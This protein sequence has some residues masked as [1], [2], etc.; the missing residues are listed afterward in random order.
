VCLHSDPLR[1]K[2]KKDQL[3]VLKRHQMLRDRGVDLF[4]ELRMKKYF[5]ITEN[6]DSFIENSLA[7]LIR[8]TAESDSKALAFVLLYFEKEWAELQGDYLMALEI[9]EKM[10]AIL[11][12]AFYIPQV[13]SPYELVYEQARILLELDYR[14]QATTILY[15]AKDK[16]DLENECAQAVLELLFVLELSQGHIQKAKELL[17]EFCSSTFFAKY[18]PAHTKTKWAYYTTV[19]YFRNNQPK[20]FMSYVQNNMQHNTLELD[21]KLR[22]KLMEILVAVDTHMFDYADRL[23]E[24]LRKFVARNN[25]RALIKMPH[26]FELIDLLWQ[27]KYCGYDLNRLEERKV[28]LDRFISKLKAVYVQMPLNSSLIRWD[29]WFTKKLMQKADAAQLYYQAIQERKQAYI[30]TGR[31]SKLFA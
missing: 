6:L 29:L 17:E 12:T 27:L 16:L 10:Q 26:L 4:L 23:Q 13:Q 25:L 3:F 24:S 14:D 2:E 11:E 5:G 18:I 1:F 7:T 22:I 31:L 15:S 9:I 19:L 28:N 21:N 30:K 20:H 8:H